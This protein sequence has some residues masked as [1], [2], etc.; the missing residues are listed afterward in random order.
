MRHPKT[1]VAPEMVPLPRAPDLFG[2]S[3]SALYRHAALGNIRLIK[4]GSRTLVDAQSVRT[5]L[6]SLPA[7]QP[8]CDPRR[9]GGKL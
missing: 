5:F 7:I 6:A 9:N 8:R 2:L 3:R 1:P 4:H